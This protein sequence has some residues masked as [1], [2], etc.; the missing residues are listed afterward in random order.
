LSKGLEKIKKYNKHIATSIERYQEVE[1]RA[2]E[3]TGIYFYR[4]EATATDYSGKRFVEVRKMVLM[5]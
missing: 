4:L 2:N 3:S 1:W 5:K